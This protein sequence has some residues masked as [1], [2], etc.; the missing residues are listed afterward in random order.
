MKLRHLSIA[1]KLRMMMM[2]TT[3]VSLLLASF[4]FVAVDI[5]T[6]RTS[7][8]H[9]AETMADVTALHS[10]APLLFN[11]RETAQEVLSALKANGSI[12]AAIIFDRNGR[13][14]AWYDA[15]GGVQFEPRP[16]DLLPRR[17]HAGEQYVFRDIRVEGDVVGTLFVACDVR[18]P[19]S[20]VRSYAV[21]VVTIL[22]VS[23]LLAF[24]VSSGLQ[25]LISS[26][27]K[28]LAR[29]AKEVTLEKNYATRVPIAADDPKNEI[30]NLIVAFNQMLAEIERRDA[31][32]ENHRIDLER[33]VTRRTAEL[34]ATVIRKHL[35]LD[36]AAEGIVAM[37]DAGA[38]TLI[39]KSA[40]DTLGS[41][42]ADLVGK[43]LHD[44]IH[45]PDQRTPRI[46][47]CV[48]CSATMQSL[49]RAGK[50][51]ALMN[52]QG[53]LIP[54]EY[55][56]S[57]IVDTRSS[58]PSGV[59]VTFRDITERLAIDRMKDEFVSTVSHELR[60]PLTSIRGA[61]GLLASGLIGNITERGQKMLDIAV[62]NTDRLVRL[63]NDI[64]DLERIDSGRVELNHTLCDAADL[65]ATAVDGIQTFAD[66]A[67][68]QIDVAPIQ[69]SLWVD[70]DRIIQT[71]TNLLS[72]AV[73][74]SPPGS[75]VRVS[76]EHGCDMFTFVVEDNGRGIPASHLESIFER[77]KQ[78]DSSDSRNKN[79][80][81]L[82]LAIC[83]SIV[84]AHGG[85]IW[86]QSL[87][88]QGTTFR[89]TVP[90][91]PAK[92]SVGEPRR[93]IVFGD[94][95][96]RDVVAQRGFEVL[97]CRGVDDLCQSCGDG[98]AD[99]ILIDLAEDSTHALQWLERVKA[100]PHCAVP[101]VVAAAAPESFEQC[102][103]AIARWVAKPC[104]NSEI[105][106]AV[107][108]AVDAPPTVLLVEDDVDLA[109]VIVAS[110]Q[111]RGIDARHA[112]TGHE[113]IDICRETAP[114][115]LILDLGLP[116]VDGFGVV[117]WMKT[118]SVLAHT[119]LVVYSAREV[120]IADQDRLRLGPT[121]FLTKSR[122]TLEQFESRVVELLNRVTHASP[123]AKAA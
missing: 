62:T 23:L 7:R 15:P 2:A 25:R 80:T 11:D 53:A 52:R 10:G 97:A 41:R 14:F 111:T 78:V 121:E 116:D 6:F 55:T 96:L 94:A 4:A 13:P 122:V 91:Q 39:N 19:Y 73:K 64:L 68:V 31:E 49:V 83:K 117:E 92:A 20:H 90:T 61:L 59:V 93:V 30:G 66:R 71:L 1:R 108:R 51:S 118:N 38:I 106:D 107:A 36:S 120:S 74:F 57:T 88:G 77:F 81:G 44:V 100:G 113:A 27:I 33:Q 110:L 18:V 29:V 47:D 58:M 24:F 26:P 12:Y 109:R 86:A 102:A 99:A 89:F 87:Q 37:D 65:I 40:A 3:S 69:Q 119:P 60:T 28:R 123:P 79:G 67:E 16:L 21:A 9:D 98:A 95:A 84:N 82:G 101:V 50:R 42:I 103:D 22:I 72:N 5:G 104:S 85:K 32:L 105:A 114:R 43:K 70:G 34:R 75:T 45:P 112:T 63:I 54:I 115:I 8:I 76:G 48:M 35:I 46:A 17:P 56:A